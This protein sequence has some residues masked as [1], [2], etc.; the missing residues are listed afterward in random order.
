MELVSQLTEALYMLFVR[1]EN[2][3]LQICIINLFNS[4]IENDIYQNHMLDL[5]NYTFENFTLFQNLDLGE[6]LLKFMTSGFDDFENV[7]I[8]SVIFYIYFLGKA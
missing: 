5:V 6:A 3:E 7:L 8:R 4:L 2:P 1:I